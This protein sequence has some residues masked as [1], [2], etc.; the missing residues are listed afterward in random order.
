LREIANELAAAGF[1]TKHGTTHSASVV[2][3][4]LAR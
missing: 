4:M 3:R 1:V 2:K